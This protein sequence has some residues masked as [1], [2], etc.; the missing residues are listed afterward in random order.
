MTSRPTLVIGNR[1]YSSWSLRPWILAQHLNIDLD[2]VR[3]VLDT[4]TFHSE[5]LAYSPTGRVP[6]LIH[7]ELVI[8]ESIA[9]ME[10]LSELADGRG[11][12]ESRGTR[13]HA[14]AYAF[15]HVCPACG[16]AAVREIDDKGEVD[17]V[18]RCT[19]GLVCPA[20]AVERLKH[21]CSR[22]AMDIEGLG[23]KQIE[24]FFEKGLIKTPA[25]IFTLQRRD[26]EPGRMQRI[27]NYEG[28]GETSV[29]NLF[30]AIE[31]RREAPLNRFIFALGIRHVGETNARRLARHFGSFENLRRV[32]MAATPDSEARA[33]LNAISGIGDVVAEGVA[34]FFAE[35]HNEREIDRLMQEVTPQPMEAVK[36]DSPVAGKTVV[37]TG[38]LE[39]FTREEAKAQAE[40]LGAKVSGSVSKKTDILVAGPGAGSKLTKAAELGVEVI[41]EDDWLAR[42]GEGN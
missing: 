25:D 3:I 13:A 34:D 39:K 37:F 26:E 10:Y 32:A 27:R 11:W 9:I 38:A 35:P 41:S 15:T 28:F 19:G 21:F 14:R 7:D 4:P 22:N 18:R 24:F 29:R 40:R 31:A 42:I 6:V 33:E 23:D 1:N 8:P 5:A 30:A 16:S 20:Q 12:P 2:I 17:A 36:T